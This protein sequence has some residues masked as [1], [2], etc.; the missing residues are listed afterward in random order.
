MH[1]S[2]KGLFDYRCLTHQQA[3]SQHRCVSHPHRNICEMKE[4]S[5]THAVR[6]GCTPPP[7]KSH[8]SSTHIT[9]LSDHHTYVAHCKQQCM[10]W[11]GHRAP[12]DAGVL[13]RKML[14]WTKTGRTALNINSPATSPPAVS[15]Q[16]EPHSQ[17]ASSHHHTAPA[18]CP[19]FRAAQPSADGKH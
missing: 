14:S 7:L 1:S 9:L 5:T 19:R 13:S 10:N 15:P 4:Q 11:A 8:M 2:T 12:A 16:M 18:V 6:T 17:P 3:L